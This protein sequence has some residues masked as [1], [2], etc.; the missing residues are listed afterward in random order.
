MHRIIMLV[1]AAV[2][3][4]SASAQ[5]KS[6]KIAFPDDYRSTY[7]NY[8]SLDRTQNADQT[9]RLFAND[10]AMQGPGKDGKLPYGSILVAEV[11]KAKLD[12]NGVAITSSRRHTKRQ[13]GHGRFQT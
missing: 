3:L 8:L 12:E 6:K 1:A 2:F 13:L 10:V 5:D 9:I 7:T 4:T 11:Y